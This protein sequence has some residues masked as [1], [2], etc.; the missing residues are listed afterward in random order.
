MLCAHF[1]VWLL[2]IIGFTYCKSVK[3]AKNVKLPK[4]ATGCKCKGM[5]IDP[6]TCECALHNGSDFPYVSQNGG[7][8][9]TKTGEMPIKFCVV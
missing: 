9:E 4:A 2:D 6:T 8:L 7:R 5:C 3:V 1:T